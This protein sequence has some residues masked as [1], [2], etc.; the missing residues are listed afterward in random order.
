M[1]LALPNT[2]I[3]G[4]EVVAAG[5]F[6]PPGGGGRGADMYAALPAF[7]RVLATLTPSSDSDINVEV[8]LPADADDWNGKY[9]AVGNGAFTGSIRHNSLAQ[10]LARGYAG[11]STDTGHEGNTA[12]FGL[13]HPEK[14]IDFGWR[15][16]HE[17]SDVSKALIAAYYDEAPRYSYWVGCSAGGRQAMKAAQRFPDDFDGIVAGAPGNAWTDRAGGALRVAKPLEADPAM[18][19]PEAT[20]QLVHDAVLAACD[21]ADGVEDGVVGDPEGCDFDPGALA[22]QGSGSDGCLTPPQVNAV[23]M[24]YASPENPATAGRS[25]AAA[26]QRAG[27]DRPGLDAV[28]PQHRPRAVPLPDVRRPGLDD[29]PVQ[30]RDRHRP[31]RGG[32]QRHAERD[33]P[34]PA[35]LLR[36]GRQADR[37]PRL[38]RPA[39]LAGERD[40]VLQP[41][42]RHAGR[43]RRRARQL[44]PLHGPRDGP[45]RRRQ[46]PQPLRHADRARNLGGGGHGSHLRPGRAPARRPGRPH[47]PPL[48]VSRAGGLRR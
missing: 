4:A 19:L 14:V 40:A 24:I 31:G 10:A 1:S 48:P 35:A 28:S 47:P 13:G 33:R 18:Q 20:R 30:F 15:A 46:R 11:S 42:P 37:L 17:M 2:G 26:R 12:S 23:R 45:L 3:T 21:A 44:P 38:G 22:C 6:M 8:W 7:C 16:V 36:P 9:Q 27:L 29:R 41:R 25:P 43:P 5:A 32:G 39:D 34:E